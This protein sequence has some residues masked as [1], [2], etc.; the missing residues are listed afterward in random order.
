MMTTESSTPLFGCLRF[1]PQ[2]ERRVK[3]CMV[4]KPLNGTWPGVVL[5]IHPLP[6]AVRCGDCA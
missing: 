5:R 4:V 3:R 2:A 1:L 6:Q